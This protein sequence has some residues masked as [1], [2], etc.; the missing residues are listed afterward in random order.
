MKTYHIIFKEKESDFM[1]KGRNF[2]ASGVQMALRNFLDMYPDAQFIAL[3][4]LDA[5]AEMKG[6]RKEVNS[7]TQRS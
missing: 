3:Y 1:S 6:N 4:D 5:L 2:T 7:N